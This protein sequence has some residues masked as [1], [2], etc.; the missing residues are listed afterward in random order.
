MSPIR[1]IFKPYDSANENEGLRFDPEGEE[2]NEPVLEQVW[3]YEFSRIPKTVLRPHVH[4]LFPFH[5]QYADFTVSIRRGLTINCYVYGPS[6]A[7]KGLHTMGSRMFNFNG[8]CFDDCPP[9]IND[10][11]CHELRNFPNHGARLVNYI[12]RIPK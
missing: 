9:E 1:L 8:Q 10:I 4:G 11:L 7:K 12:L 5:A 2:S 6:V 3:C